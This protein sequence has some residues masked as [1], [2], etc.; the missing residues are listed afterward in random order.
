MKLIKSALIFSGLLVIV[1]CSSL[2]NGHQKNIANNITT[3]RINTTQC[4]DS[5]DWY[6]DGYRVGKSFR[7][8]KQKMLQQRSTY[9]G[10]TLSRLPSKYRKNWEQGF[11]IGIKG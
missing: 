6:L 2:N 8:E 5:D 11:R 7:S 1:G 4:K 10:Y 3:K 9:C